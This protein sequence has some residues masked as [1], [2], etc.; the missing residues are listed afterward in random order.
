M[1]PV[2]HDPAPVVVGHRGAPHLARENTPASFA[3]ALAAG[4]SWVELDVRRSADDALVVH[5]D[6]VTADGRPLVARSAD[7]LAALG[8]WTLEEVL[9]RLPPGAG[10]DVEVK[11]TPG[12]PDHDE[13]D[14]VVAALPSVLGDHAG[15][16]PL[17]V[18]SFNPRTVAAAREGLPD[19][20]TGLV[21]TGLQGVDAA[22]ALAGELGAQAV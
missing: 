8:V 4:A 13:A 1:S 17:L 7:A 18:S 20:P 10:V 2:W 11:N 16:R 19:A 21:H 6:P 5:H 15:G 9:R 14:M 3:A 22:V 12:E